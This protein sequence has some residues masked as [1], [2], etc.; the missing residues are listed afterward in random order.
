MPERKEAGAP[1]FA[2]FV[3]LMALMMSLVALSIDAV[4]PALTVIGTELGAGAANQSQLVIGVLFTGLALGQL[5][6]GPLSD[7]WG[8]KRAI[9]LGYALFIVGCLIAL[10]AHSFE[11]MLLGR[12]LQGLGVA[13]PRVVSLALVRDR[14]QGR[15]M[16]RVM[17]FVMTI[18][19]LVPMIAPAFGQALMLIADWRA[20]FVAFLLVSMTTVCWFGYRLPETLAPENRR[21]LTRRMLWQGMCAVLG[22]RITLGYTLAA[23]TV[24]GAFVGYLNSAPSIFQD[25]YQVGTLFPLYFALLGLSMMAASLLNSRL[26]MRYG[27]SRLCHCGLWAIMTLSCIFLIVVGF[28]HGTPPFWSF[29]LYLQVCFFF[30]G[31]LF[32]NLNAQAMEPVGKVAGMGAAVIG[33]LSTFISVPVGVLIGQCFNLTLWPLVI[34]FFV[35]SVSALMLIYWAERPA[36][37]IA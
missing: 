10:F 5:F 28:T 20:I 21:P 37:K 7:S 11:Q 6:Y 23:G 24:F 32:G 17:S 12:L 33:S 29:M 19:I 13:G 34:G 22:E 14:Y 35:L 26:V 15:V 8:R 30:V 25:L 9:Y 4:L 3:T 18:F 31:L 1:G 2:E 27:M 16:A 36:L